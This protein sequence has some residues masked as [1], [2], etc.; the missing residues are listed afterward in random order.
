MLSFNSNCYQLFV[1]HIFSAIYPGSLKMEGNKIL[2]ER[3]EI[4]ECHHL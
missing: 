1:T 2:R 4:I 3:W